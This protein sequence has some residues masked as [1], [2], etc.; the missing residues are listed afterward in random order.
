MMQGDAEIVSGRPNTVGFDEVV[1]LLVR[2]DRSV[3]EKVVLAM[4]AAACPREDVN[5]NQLVHGGELGPVDLRGQQT[6]R[7][8]PSLTEL[9]AGVAGRGSELMDQI[10]AQREL[11]WPSSVS[12][13]QLIARHGTD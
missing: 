12:F 2:G 8:Q 10:R 7:D 11:E 13:A 3:K 9:L 1:Q 5:G 6:W 4:D